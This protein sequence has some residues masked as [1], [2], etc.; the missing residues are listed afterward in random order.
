MV[1]CI[2]IIIDTYAIHGVLNTSDITSSQRCCL[3]L[4]MSYDSAEVE[5][6]NIAERK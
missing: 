5:D 2:M 1:T 4:E 6:G 3:V